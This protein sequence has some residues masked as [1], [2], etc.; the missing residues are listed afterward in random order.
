MDFAR[1]FSFRRPQQRRP[2]SRRRKPALRR[3]DSLEK[4]YLLS[5]APVIDVLSAAVGSGDDVDISGHVSDFDP[6]AGALSVAISGP[7]ATNLAVDSAGDFSYTGPAAQLGT[8][9][10]VATDAGT[11]LSSAAVQTPIENAAPVIQNFTVSPT[12][13]G[14]NVLLSGSVQ[15]ES[16]SGLTVSFSGVASGSATTDASGNFS[17]VALASGLGN[18]TAATNDV[19]GAASQ[20]ASATLSDSGPV[21]QLNPPQDNA[22]GTVTISGTVSDMT[23]GGASVSLSGVVSGTATTDS[24]GAFSLTAQPSGSGTVTATATDVWNQTSSPAQT[25]VSSPALVSSTSPSSTTTEMAPLTISNLVA[26]YLGYG[27]WEITGTVSGGDLSTT[28]ISYS[29]TANG[30]TTPDSSGNFSFYVLTSGPY[31]DGYETVTA[32]D[33]EGDTDSQTIYFGM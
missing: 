22:D 28:T 5:S 1:L 20:P 6:N 21:V 25:T 31:Y 19:W 8:E 13:N 26:N 10:A 32:S 2:Q 23:P 27:Q 24:S 16:P 30:S 4:R 14:T 12:G 9:Q 7:I 33:A 29:G 18:V 3:F 11:G 15:D 17:F